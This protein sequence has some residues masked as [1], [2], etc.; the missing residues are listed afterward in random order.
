MDFNGIECCDAELRRLFNLESP[1]SAAEYRRLVAIP[2]YLRTRGNRN[3]KRRLMHPSRSLAAYK[4]PR[5]GGK[6]AKF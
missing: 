6:F 3:F 4:K 5:I 2:R 1:S